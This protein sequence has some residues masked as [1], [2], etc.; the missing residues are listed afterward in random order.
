[1][2]RCGLRTID[3]LNNAKEKEE[4]IESKRIATAFTLSSSLTPSALAFGVKSDPFAGL[5]VLL[6]PPKV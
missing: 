6:L 3:K 1:M 5:K 4:Q 2:V